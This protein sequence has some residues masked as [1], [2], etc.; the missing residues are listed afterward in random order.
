[1]LEKGRQIMWVVTIIGA[2]FGAAWFVFGGVLS[3]S[4]PQSAAIAAQAVAL[5]VIP[6]VIA[7]AVSEMAA[8]RRRRQSED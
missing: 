2:L 8:E 7:R 3:A 4:A 1:M 6:Y 5:A